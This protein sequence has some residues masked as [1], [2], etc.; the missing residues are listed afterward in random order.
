MT[1]G[2]AL[3]DGRPALFGVNAPGTKMERLLSEGAE[4]VPTTDDRANALH[5]AM[6]PARE[7]S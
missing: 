6:Q 2:F 1:K 3:I 4:F 5:D 7:R